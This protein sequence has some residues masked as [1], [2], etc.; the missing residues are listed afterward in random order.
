MTGALLAL[1][2]AALFGLNSASIRRGVLTGSVLHA[3]AITV[4]AGVPLFALAYLVSADF[5]LPPTLLIPGWGWFALAGIVHFVIGRYGNYRATKAIGSTLS[6]P[7]QQISIPVSLLLAIVILDESMTI[8]RIAGVV[9]V[10][11]GPVIATWQPPGER[12]VE[13][14][15]GFRPAYR[16]GVF[17]GTFGAVAYGFSPLFI[18]KGL[19]E[20]GALTDALAGGFISYLAAGVV[21]LSIVLLAGGESF[22]RQLD[23]TAGKWFILSSG[24]VFLSQMFRY[25]ALTIAPVSVVVPIQRMSIIFRVIFSWAINRDHEVFGLQLLTGALI[26]LVGALALSL[27]T[28]FVQ[29]IMPDSW[30]SMLTLQWP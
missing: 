29:S 22:M 25:I 16:E 5:E 13:T 9:L 10:I 4:P 11:A 26:S 24:L 17:W 23:R 20:S 27:S 18:M 7:L 3:L 30:S 28:A 8:L 15:S 21:I 6:A 19:G 14:R 12:V 2:S 1:S